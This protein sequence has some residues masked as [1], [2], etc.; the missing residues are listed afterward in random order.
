MKFNTLLTMRQRKVC[1]IFLPAND[2]SLRCFTTKLKFL[3]RYLTR[4]IA[5]EKFL[6]EPYCQIEYIAVRFT[7][8][9][10]L[11]M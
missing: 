6:L 7:A 8:L 10:P 4:H 2:A 9:P 1:Q 3:P 11:I 5:H